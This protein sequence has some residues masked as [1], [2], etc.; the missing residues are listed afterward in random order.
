MSVVI[1]GGIDRLKPYYLKQGRN[2]G[3]T[4]IKVFSKKFP[5]MVKRLSKFER[6]VI[7]TGNVAHTMVEGTVRMAKI[8]G[9]QVG[10]THS[11]SISAMKK[12]LE[13]VSN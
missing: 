2:L 7:C 8:N 11:S 12:C 1:L 13:Q 9:I 6:I 3:F 4:E 5:D 10:R